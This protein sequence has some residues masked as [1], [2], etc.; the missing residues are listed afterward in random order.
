MD[1]KQDVKKVFD[2]QEELKK[3]PNKPGVYIMKDINGDIIYIGKAVVL[4]NRVRQYFQSLSNQTPKVRAMVSHI[5]EFEYIVTDTELEALILECNLIKKHRPKFNILL[6]DDKSYPYIKVTMNEDFPRILMTRRIEKDGAKYFGPYTSVF[7]VR[8]TI[9]LVKKLFPIKTCSKVLPRDIGKGRPC[10]NYHI[11]Q[12]LGPCQGNVSKDEYRALMQD[13]CSFLGGRQEDI[14][15][16]LEKDM[17]E[18]ADKLEFEKAAKI[19]DKINSLRHIA[20]K[21]KIISTA[22]EDQD[23]IAFAK[24]E[25]DSCIQV[26]FIRG[27]KLIGR[28]HFILEGTSDVSDSELMTAFVKQFYSSAAYVPSQVI[29]QEDIDEIDI[30]EK[31]LSSKRTAKTHIKVPRRG[32]KLKLVEMVS[33]NALIELNQ[34]KERIKKETALAN[35]GM[36]K[37]KELLNLERLPQRIEAYDI[38][39]TGS[40][41][42]VGSMVVFENGA[43]KK[44]DYRRFKIKST[45]IQNDYQSM[46][47]VIFRRF[48]RAQRE[49]IGNDADDKK[50]I[51]EGGTGFGTLPDVLLVDGGIGHVNAVRSVL[52]EFDFNIPVYGMVKDDNHRT[53]GLVSGKNEFDLSKDIIL[54]RF[55]TAIQ[56]EA[57]RF[58][59]EYNKKLRA[60]RYSGSVLDSIEGVGLK[61]KKA[62]IKHFGSVRAIKE[63]EP[64]E[65]A[66]VKGISKELAQKIYDYFRQ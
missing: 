4:K 52:G 55:V 42:I 65:I 9:D 31:W 49:M 2:I 33:K 36:K 50:E 26:F 23:V 39:N 14:I 60:K 27:G 43:P 24:S 1:K 11:Y 18:A 62:L 5:K 61:R 28:E 25:T 17:K 37:L 19:R 20:E 32:E 64:D 7:A 29:L 47:E 46:Q 15:K 53:R 48:K 40:T 58:A 16:R 3:L 6:K 56:D 10:L 38:S 57:H 8:E 34:F 12:C 54:L 45:N 21:Q 35:E 41:E 51:G 30:I 66:K 44:S 59:L 63:A 22:M 13:I